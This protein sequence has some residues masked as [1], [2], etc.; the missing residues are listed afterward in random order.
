MNQIVY[1]DYDQEGLDRQYNA[2]AASR[3]TEGYLAWGTEASVGARES[4]PATLN[5]AYGPSEAE[6]LDIFGPEP[7]APPGPVQLFIHGGYWR[8]FHKDDFSYVAEPIVAAGGVSVVVNYALMPGVTMDE[9]VR[10]CRAALA[11]TYQNIGAHGG[12]PD[13]VCISGHSAG[14]HLVAMMLATDWEADFGLPANVIKGAVAISGLFDLT[15]IQLSYLN[16]DLKMD[17]E[18]ARRM[19]PVNCVADPPP[20]GLPPIM[21]TYGGLES[22]E[23]ARQTA[24]YAETLRNRG[25]SCEIEPILGHHHMSVVTSLYEAD[26]RLTQMTMEQ[27]GLL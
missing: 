19:S 9:L 14:G 11:W 17:A 8:A 4:L 22:E 10:Q 5:V 3:A 25:H 12:D 16:E 23:F 20:G 6:V 24:V 13:R 21:L 1:R 15:P 2:R 27:M 26:S 7:S 18:T